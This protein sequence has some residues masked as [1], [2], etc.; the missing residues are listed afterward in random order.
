MLC[1]K[2]C[3][4]QLQET[5]AGLSN[6]DGTCGF[7]HPVVGESDRPPLLS[8]EKMFIIFTRFTIDTK[9]SIEH[10]LKSLV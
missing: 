5:V 10:K 8:T 2:P 9:H 6:G 1:K 3:I 7:I 4:K